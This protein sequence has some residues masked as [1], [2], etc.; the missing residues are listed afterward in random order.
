MH[1]HRVA[2][3]LVGSRSDRISI[4]TF[5]VSDISKL[6]V[7]MDSRPI[8]PN[9]FHPQSPTLSRDL[10]HF[11]SARSRTR[12]PVKYY[13]TDFGHARKYGPDTTN[14]LEIPQFGGDRTVPEFQHDKLTPRNPFQTDI[15]YI[16]NLIRTY[17][18]QVRIILFVT[19]SWF[20]T[21][22]P[23]G[24]QQ[25]NVHGCSHRSHGSG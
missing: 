9:E 16:G 25:Y 1:E 5:N 15:Y 11:V 24:L 20:L 4:L 18:L 10:K 3:R 7:M 12:C 19:P 14:P 17:F 23:T 2:H 13:F 22:L 8:L 21:C 6:N